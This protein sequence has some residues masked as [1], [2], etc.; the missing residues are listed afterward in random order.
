MSALMRVVFTAQP[1]S[2][3][4]FDDLATGV[5]E[6]GLPERIVRAYER[7]RAEVGEASRELAER[8]RA[9]RAASAGRSSV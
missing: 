2:R 1:A 8:R 5:R 9:A 3:A 7:F 4:V 6:Q